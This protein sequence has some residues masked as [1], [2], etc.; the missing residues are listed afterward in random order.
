LSNKQLLWH[1]TGF[2]NFA[3]ILANGL[4]LPTEDY[5][6][7]NGWQGKGIYFAN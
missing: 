6:L 3:D 2:V 4:K 1:G 5:P 7:A